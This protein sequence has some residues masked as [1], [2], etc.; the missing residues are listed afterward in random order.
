M[1]RPGKPNRRGRLSTVDVHVLTILNLLLFTLKI[2]FSFFAKQATLMKRLLIHSLPLLL[3]FLPV[4]YVCI[5]LA[6]VE[7]CTLKGNSRVA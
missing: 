2:L 1:V 6:Y 5:N 3:V 4:S 7:V